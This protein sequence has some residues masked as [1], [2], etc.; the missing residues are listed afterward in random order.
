MKRITVSKKTR[1]MCHN[2]SNIGTWCLR[3]LHTRRYPTHRSTSRGKTPRNGTYDGSPHSFSSK[4]LPKFVYQNMK[5]GQKL[6]RW[7]SCQSLLQFLANYYFLHAYSSARWFHF[8]QRKKEQSAEKPPPS[9][10]HRHKT[11]EFQQKRS[12]SGILNCVVTCHNA[13][14]MCWL[15]RHRD[16]RCEVP[17]S[18]NFFITIL[19]LLLRKAGVLKM[20][21][22]NR[23]TTQTLST[24][25][26]RHDTKWLVPRKKGHRYLT[27]KV[28]SQTHW[29]KSA[30]E[31][32]VNCCK[33]TVVS[34]FCGSFKL[35]PVS[36]RQWTPNSNATSPDHKQR[37]KFART[38]QQIWFTFHRECTDSWHEFG[39]NTSFA[40]QM[41]L[42][43]RTSK[44]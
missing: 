35:F 28:A 20:V 21:T 36:R 2:W 11:T 44:W 12:T 38:V 9:S 26:K 23:S 33:F 4:R 32:D 31:N 5:H 24:R 19:P 3:R 30:V 1:H 37:F 6:T 18:D 43:F 17:W 41:F 34:P 22:L 15:I 7:S 27:D 39:M 40:Q 29:S 42:P 16:F 8:W 25:W 10:L 14:Q 13:T